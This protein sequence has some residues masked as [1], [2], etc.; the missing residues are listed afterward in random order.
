MEKIFGYDMY[1][2]ES[3]AMMNIDFRKEYLKE[4]IEEKKKEI[5]SLEYQI[6]TAFDDDIPDL[7]D[8]LEIAEEELNELEK[9][10]KNY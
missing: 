10:L 1:G 5:K 7:E 6:E 4:D 8:K 2:D 3:E 9:A